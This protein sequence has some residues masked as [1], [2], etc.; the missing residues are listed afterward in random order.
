MHAENPVNSHRSRTGWGLHVAAFCAFAIAAL[1]NSRP[2]LMDPST[3]VTL[4]LP[5]DAVWV[6]DIKQNV[7]QIA[8][9]SRALWTNPRN[10]FEGQMCYPV[11]AGISLGEHMLGEGLLALPAYLLWD[12]PLVTFNFVVTVRPLIGA[13]SMYALAY[14]WTGSFA[15]ALIAGFAFGFHPMRLHDLIHPSVVGNELIPAILLSLHL[16]MTRGRWRDVFI[17]TVLAA[18]QMLESLYVLLQVAIAVGIYGPYLL[19]RQ[20]RAI[21]ALLPKLAV[22]AMPLVALAAW[23]FGPYLETRDVW[24]VLQGRGAFPTPAH[25][26]LPGN[27]YYP[28]SCLLL[29]ASLGLLDR[30][31]GAR[32][33]IGGYDPRLPM[34]LIAVVALWFVFGWNVPV[35]GWHVQPLRAILLPWL[36]GLDAVRA[37]GNALFVAAV[38]LGLLAAY[39]VRALGEK[40]GPGPRAIIAGL[41]AI[42]CV[43]EVFVPAFAERSFDHPLPTTSFRIRPPDRDVAVVRDLP[44]WPV[45]NIPFY[46]RGLGALHMGRGVL[47]A[48]YH[49]RRLAACKAS[50]I[51]PAQ[52]Q[53]EA[54]AGRLPSAS[55]AQELWALGLRTI[56]FSAQDEAKNRENASR[57]SAGLSDRAAG[58]HLV[59]IGEGETIRVF[60]IEGG[61]PTTTDIASLSPVV[62]SEVQP[63]ARD[64]LLRFGV[65]SGD[66]LFRHPDPLQPKDL[67]VTWTRDGTTVQSKRTRALL[68]MA[69]APGRTAEIVVEDR[70]PSTP[71]FYVVTLALADE[72]GHVVGRRHVVVTHT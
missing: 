22:V 30:V 29:L 37:P 52:D 40:A 65:R 66:S 15:A 26:V 25:F 7:A 28:G 12:D 51:T 39:G 34:A 60:K 31:R 48:A 13:L 36:P 24:G 61:A 1:W 55:A 6:S 50:F 19:W 69:V 18:L 54:I 3:L 72:P 17:L 64:I 49:E 57:I 59:P 9:V 43:G 27:R 8:Y 41:V 4:R 70:I 53:V 2:A 67:V 58:A 68:P 45:L 42:A 10:F 71:G 32:R 62:E 35:A 11:P 33:A 47:L 44:P 63:A 5:A 23:V 20:R 16:L 56:I 21:P 38:S 14:Y 46:N